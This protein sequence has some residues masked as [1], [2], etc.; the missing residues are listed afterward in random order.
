MTRNVLN[1]LE[2]K[3]GKAGEIL[4]NTDDTGNVLL[5]VSSGKLVIYNQNQTPVADVDEGHFVLLPAEK[6][7]IAIAITS[8]RLILM[9][10]GPLSEMITDDPEWNPDRPVILP[11]CPSLAKTLYIIEYYQNEK[12]SELN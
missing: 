1:Q 2:C 12:R 11:I 7:F 5:F 10:A 3:I 6:S 8:T 9:H 4:C